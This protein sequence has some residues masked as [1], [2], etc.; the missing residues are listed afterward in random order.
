LTLI[1]EEFGHEAALF[2]GIFDPLCAQQGFDQDLIPNWSLN[3]LLVPIR[4][5]IH[6]GETFPS[7]PLVKTP[8]EQLLGW[9]GHAELTSGRLGRG[10][11]KPVGCARGKTS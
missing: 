11:E 3:S 8:G 1:F 4:R 5:R 10:M 7:V 2:I 9:L 6:D